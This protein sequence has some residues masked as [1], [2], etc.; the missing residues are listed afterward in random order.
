MPAARSSAAKKIS[1][2]LPMISLA[3]HPLMRAAPVFQLDTRPSRS[4]MKM[5]QSRTPLISSWNFSSLLRSASSAR[6]SSTRSRTV[7]T[8]I[9]AVATRAAPKHHSMVR[10]RPSRI[11]PG[12]STCIRSSVARMGGASGC[13]RRAGISVSVERPT[14]CAG[15]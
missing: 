1:Y 6:S 4:S 7:I 13:R 14:S 12:S 3:F 9:G 10:S 2:G 8:K 15:W 11:R 5:A